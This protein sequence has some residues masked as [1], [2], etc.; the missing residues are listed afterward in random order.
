S[1]NL[2]LFAFGIQAA[3]L[4]IVGHRRLDRIL[5]ED[6]AVDLDRRERQLLGDLR[7]LDRYRLVERLALDPFGDQRARRDRRAAAVG[8]EAGVLD[9]AVTSDPDL[10]LHH[11]AAGRRADHA[12]ADR[13]VRLVERADVAR[14][15]IMIDYLVAVCHFQ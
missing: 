6:R 8:L 7:V 11:V 14:V 5:G 10:Q 3:L 15:L 2:F 1:S 4:A 12:G 9:A 13:L